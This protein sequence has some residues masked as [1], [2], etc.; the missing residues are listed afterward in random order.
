[1]TCGPRRGS[2]VVP[3]VGLPSRKPP[4][5]NKT[6]RWFTAFAAAGGG[7]DVDNVPAMMELTRRCDSSLHFSSMPGREVWLYQPV[8]M[9]WTVIAVALEVVEHAPAGEGGCPGPAELLSHELSL[10]DELPGE[11]VVWI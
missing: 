8:L 4:V 9:P 5:V 11:A 10:P 7:D 1:M 3:Q 2:R 6:W